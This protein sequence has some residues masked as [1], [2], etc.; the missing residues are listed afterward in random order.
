MVREFVCLLKL[1]W[2]DVLRV[3][4]R[5]GVGGETEFASFPTEIVVETKVWSSVQ[6]LVVSLGV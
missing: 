4:R 5:V 3:D 1:H 2:P 6:S